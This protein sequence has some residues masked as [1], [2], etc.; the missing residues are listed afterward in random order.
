MLDV[1]SNCCGDAVGIWDATVTNNAE[2]AATG[3][4]SP[5]WQETKREQYK[6]ETCKSDIRTH[7]R[8][9]YAESADFV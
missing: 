5:T 6:D 1:E 2:P 7:D 4:L 3:L 9:R 8:D